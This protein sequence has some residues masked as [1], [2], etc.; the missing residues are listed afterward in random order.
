MIEGG[1]EDEEREME[2]EEREM[3][4]EED[5]LVVDKAMEVNYEEEEEVRLLQGADLTLKYSMYV[6]MMLGGMCLHQFN[7]QGK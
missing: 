1:G 7:F 3:E 6:D 2:V 5:V 4:G